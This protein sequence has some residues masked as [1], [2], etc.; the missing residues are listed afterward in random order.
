MLSKL[1]LSHFHIYLSWN[2]REY[3][4][5]WRH[6]K[7]TTVDDGG[8]DLARDLSVA[9]A[10]A[11]ESL[12]DVQ[13]VL[14]CNLAEDDVFAVEPGGDDG[15]DE[16]LGAVGVGT[17]IGHGEQTRFGVVSL[18]VLIRELLTVDGLS[19]STI[20]T[21]EVAALKHEL[22]DD[23]MEL[24]SLVPE[25]LLTGAE[26]TEVLGRLGDYIVVEVEVDATLFGAWR[27][28]LLGGGVTPFDVEIGFDD[29]CGW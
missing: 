22:R 1:L 11:F 23:T 6:L 26:S 19:S 8:G 15:G 2:Y 21:S 17:G 5:E 7:L 18:E 13:G 25:A 20:T 27:I 3:M 14:V 16:E 10:S 24:G 29:H 12:D 28:R 9:R 4:S